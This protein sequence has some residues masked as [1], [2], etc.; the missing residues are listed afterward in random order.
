[1]FLGEYKI[2][3]MV[4]NGWILQ[5]ILSNIIKLVSQPKWVFKQKYFRS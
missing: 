1:M 5:G 3:T 4:G 2:E